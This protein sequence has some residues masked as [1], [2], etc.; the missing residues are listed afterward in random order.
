[1]KQRLITAGILLAIC[2]PLLILGGYFLMALVAIVGL[3]AGYEL[4]SIKAK[5]AEKQ[6]YPI[7]V[8]ILVFIGILVLLF[9]N[10]H[11]DGNNAVFNFDFKQGIMTTIGFSISNLILFFILLLCGCVVSKNFKIMDACYLF[12]MVV[13]ICLSLQ[14]FMYI[15]SLP[16]NDN[17]VGS[18]IYQG[19]GYEKLN[20]IYLAIYLLVTTMMTDTGAMLGG[21]IFRKSKW[22]VH[23]LIERVSPKKTVEGAITGSLCGTLF[24]SLVFGL[25]V[26]NFELNLPIYI[27]IPL[28]LLLT[29]MAQF[30]DLIFSCVKRH[31][32]VKDYSNLLPGHGGVLDRIDSLIFNSI[33]LAGFLF[34]CVQGFGWFVA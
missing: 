26:C 11:F 30:G 33:L 31:F 10:Y 22:Q 23:P 24:G 29:I 3:F 4:L 25:L 7:G 19:Y 34:V 12:T 17:L 8:Y 20:G 5:G 9:L 27:Y 2:V 1:M 32:Q 18:V 13:V 21:M 14:G 28:T 16:L 15:R 6:V